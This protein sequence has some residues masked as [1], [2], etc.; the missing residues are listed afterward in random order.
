VH[1]GGDRNIIGSVSAH[2]KK[3]GLD[4]I[5]VTIADKMIFTRQRSNSE[6]QLQYV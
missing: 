5:Q 4:V 3:L 2:E 6:L 1:G